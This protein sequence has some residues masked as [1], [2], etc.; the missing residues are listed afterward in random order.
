MSG[1][2]TPIAIAVVE[3]EGCY[4][5]GRRDK[6]APVGGYWEFPGGKVLPSESLEQAARRECLEETGLAVE[7]GSSL[8]Q[9]EYAY[10]HDCVRLHF[11]RCILREPQRAKPRAPFRWVLADELDQY[12]FPPANAELIARLTIDSVPSSLKRRQTESENSSAG[13]LP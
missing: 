11:F 10:A 12:E 6:N 1:Q 4:L 3:H 8:G 13:E 5:V 2:P 7:V 9:R